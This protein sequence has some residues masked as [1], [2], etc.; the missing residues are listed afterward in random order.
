MLLSDAAQ[1]LQRTTHLSGA[2]PPAEGTQSAPGV[3]PWPIWRFVMPAAQDGGAENAREEY[4]VVC[5]FLRLYATLRFYRLAL[6]LGSSGS[7]ITAIATAVLRVEPYHLNMLRLAGLGVTSIFLVME[8]R[9]T[10]HWQAL[11][12]R[13]N[14]LARTLRFNQFPASN[15]WNPLTTSGAG[16]YLHAFVLV[17]WI[18]GF[19]NGRP[20]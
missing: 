7:L 12:G 9:A 18:V 6:L 16:F 19:L 8:Y 10:S 5:D 2:R 14:E 13:A 3:G 4:K 11:L 1:L 15:R 20:H 17:L